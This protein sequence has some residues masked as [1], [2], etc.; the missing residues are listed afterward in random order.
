M[1]PSHGSFEDQQNINIPD[2]FRCPITTE[3]MENPVICAD[4]H[5]Y[6]REA[7]TA[8]LRAHNTSPFT[9]EI[10]PH[11]N[12]INNI[13]LKKA[14][15]DLLERQPVLRQENRDFQMAVE[16]R[17]KELESV[18]EKR[19]KI[20]RTY[21]EKDQISE[22]FKI[23]FQSHATFFQNSPDEIFPSAPPEEGKVNKVNEYLEKQEDISNNFDIESI[24]LIDEQIDVDLSSERQRLT[25]QLMLKKDELSRSQSMINFQEK[26]GILGS[27]VTGI[28]FIWL[29]FGH[30]IDGNKANK[31]IEVLGFFL[32]DIIFFCL[33]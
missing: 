11:K 17:I 5:S 25:N 30:I 4:G 8:W 2:S 28:I 14:I 1:F 29:K 15:Q 16:I 3:I 13:N 31:A 24:S 12:L 27:L 20:N 26:I 18:L 7:I 9:N 19:S 6:E 33:H 22:D 32:F 21:E 10:L 23:G